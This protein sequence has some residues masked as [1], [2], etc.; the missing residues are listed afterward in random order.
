MR[1][2]RSYGRVT[3][4][5]EKGRGSG[6]AQGSAVPADN[7]KID[8]TID[9]VECDERYTRRRHI[10]CWL[11]ADHALGPGI[12]QLGLCHGVEV[13]YERIIACG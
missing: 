13:V 6:L 3:G 8:S 11:E 10:G 2:R 12:Q 5:T 4:A 7:S 1:F 9:G